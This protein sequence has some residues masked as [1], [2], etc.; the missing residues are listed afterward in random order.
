MLPEAASDPELPT[1]S[2]PTRSPE[3]GER[4]ASEVR[5]SA[6]RSY[7]SPQ[8]N[9]FW[10]LQKLQ[11]IIPEMKLKYKVY[12]DAA[13]QKVK[14]GVVIAGEHPAA[15]FGV[16]VLSGLLLMRGPRRFLWRQTLWRFQSEEAQLG[17]ID[18]GL[19]E[20]GQSV[21]K[22]K[23]DGKNMILRASFGEEELQRGR[24]KIRDAGKEIQRLVKSIYKIESQAADVM[25]GLRVISG[26]DALKLRAE[27]ASMTSDL[28]QQKRELDRKI[29]KI[30]EHGV[31]V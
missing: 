4:S 1:S 13:V 28:R 25:D 7:S 5:G 17:K 29:L 20:L 22:L 16:A 6:L 3:H 12:E 27:V 26:R 19:K 21:E 30:S 23:K 18:S 15:T 24:T 8:E 31:P 2:P 10:T 11:G 14:D 9:S